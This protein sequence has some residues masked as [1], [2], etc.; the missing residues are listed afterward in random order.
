LKVFRPDASLRPNT[1]DS[2]GTLGHELVYHLPRY[3]QIVGYFVER[4]ELAGGA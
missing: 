2:N 1:Q 4:K 3:H